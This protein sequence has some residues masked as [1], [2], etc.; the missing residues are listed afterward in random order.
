MNGSVFYLRKSELSIS[1]A[2]S[3]IRDPLRFLVENDSVKSRSLQIQNHSSITEVRKAL[4]ILYR[5]RA[6]IALL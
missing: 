5:I 4:P 1:A 2:E 3:F 6:V